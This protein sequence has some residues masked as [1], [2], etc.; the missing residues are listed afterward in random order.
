LR[1][2]LPL[3][4]RLSQQQVRSRWRALLLVIKAK[5][6]AVYLGVLTVDDAFLAET[7][8]RDRQTVAEYMAPQIES[9]Y[10]TGKIAPLLPFYGE[11]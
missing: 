1:F 7:V 8:R 9:A 3:G 2:A 11:S 4:T 10:A 6:E 5:L